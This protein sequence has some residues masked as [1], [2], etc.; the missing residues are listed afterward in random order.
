MNLPELVKKW[1]PTLLLGLAL[2][3]PI[4]WVVSWTI[5]IGMFILGGERRVAYIETT[6]ASIKRRQARECEIQRSAIFWMTSVSMTNGWQEPPGAERI[7]EESCYEAAS[8]REREGLQ[9]E[10]LPSVLF[11][12]A[13]AGPRLATPAPTLED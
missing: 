8:E 2:G 4:G 5:P 12:N 6:I 13:Y 7:I 3:A 1:G 11:G 10:R 9:H